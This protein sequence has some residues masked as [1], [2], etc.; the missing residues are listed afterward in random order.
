MRTALVFACVVLCSAPAFAQAPSVSADKCE[1][2]AASLKLPKTTVSS[3][4]LARV[5][6][7]F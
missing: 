3:A 4:T 6:V 7:S 2:L 1:Q 5:T